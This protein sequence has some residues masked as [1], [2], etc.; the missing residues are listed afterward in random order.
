MKICDVQH[1]KTY[2]HYE[3][4]MQ[5]CSL[6]HH[7]ITIQSCGHTVSGLPKII[8]QTWKTSQIPEHWQKSQ[9][10]WIRFHPGWTYCLW[11][12]EDIETYIRLTRPH[13]WPLF[14]SMTYAI[15]RVDL[16]RYFIMHDFGGLYSDLDIVPLKCIESY[17]IPGN[18]FVVES[19]NSS[20]IFTNALMLSAVTPESKRFWSA[21]VK[22]VSAWPSTYMEAL[23]VAFRHMHI[24]VS[25]GPLALTKV[26]RS[27]Q[28]VITVLPRTLWNPYALEH[29]GSLESQ[30][31]ALAIVQ[32]LEGSSWHQLDSTV[33]SFV[34][35]HRYKL[36][37][38]LALLCL[39]YV[40]R[41]EEIRHK[42]FSLLNRS[43]RSQSTQRVQK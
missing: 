36:I 3:K 18:I 39:Y 15:Q 42:L 9:D 32:I 24:M 20:G 34:S 22:H 26:L 40:V 31:N 28:E 13:A 37:T 2:R 5:Q 38:L 19:A 6:L 7:L 35:T 27:T 41:S 25:T 17:L 33:V 30:T 23:L 1:I 21:V 43:N 8:H 16:F 11:T 10:E 29:A 4:K 14:Q 12:D